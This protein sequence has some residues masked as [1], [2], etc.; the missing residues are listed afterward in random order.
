MK[1]TPETQTLAQIFQTSGDEVYTIPSYQRNYSWKEEQIETLF[2]DIRVEDKGY[3][4]GNLLINNTKSENNVIDGQQRLTTLSLFLLAIYEKL[5]MFEGKVGADFKISFED[6][7]TDIRRHISKNGK[8]RLTLLDKDREIWEE[9]T[10]VLENSKQLELGKLKRFT[11]YKRYSYIRE[12]LF[13]DLRSLEDVLQFF[14]KLTNIEL[15][16][17]SVPDISDAY[18]VFASLNSKGLPLTP[19]DLL[20]NIYLSSGGEVDKWNAL[21]KIFVKDEEV[22]E[23]NEVK[24]TQFVLNNYDGMENQKTAQSLTKGKLVG[25][26][27]S[28]FKE[29]GANYIDALLRRAQVYVEIA[30]DEN[31]YDFSLSGLAKLD[32]TTCYPLLLNLLVNKDEYKLGEGTIEEII[33]ILIKL[34]VRRNITLTPKASNLRHDMLS[35]KN[36]IVEGKLENKEILGIIKAE[37][38]GIMPS[39]EVVKISLEDGLYDKNKKTTRFILIN[40]ERKF[41]NYFN[42]ASQDTLDEFSNN[43]GTL[44]WTIEH[45]LPQGEELPSYWKDQI[46][47]ENEENAKNIQNDIVHKIGNLT[48]TPYNS[49]LGNKSFNEKISFKDNE[50]EVGLSLPLYLNKSINTDLDHWN[51]EDI[52]KRNDILVSEILEIF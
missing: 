5:Q 8:P 24:M 41:G 30:S 52:E 21:K 50:A 49:E 33:N 28:I 11:F 37:I 34:Y 44:K 1:I 19:L 39:D 35:I 47:P 12:K 31:S 7:N 43:N 18:Q 36:K 3:Y 14:N 10:V 42:K 15:L 17:I 23:I 48:L 29:K 16:K 20:K 38:E 40:L 4:V 51:V 27:Q 25:S 22:T 2:N 26:Y 45:I 9:L 32:A 46:S 6:A 13:A